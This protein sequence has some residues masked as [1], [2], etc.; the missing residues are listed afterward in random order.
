METVRA[1][2]AL[3]EQGDACRRQ[4]RI[5]PFPRIQ[6][7]SP[8][9]ELPRMEL[10]L[11]HGVRAGNLNCRDERLG[12]TSSTLLEKYFLR[13][14]KILFVA[15]SKYFQRISGENSLK[16]FL[17]CGFRIFHRL[18]AAKR[19]SPPDMSI[20][21]HF[22]LPE[23]C[24]LRPL[25]QADPPWH[26]ASPFSSSASSRSYRMLFSRSFRP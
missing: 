15:P 13:L 8:T 17:F 3:A 7:G 9:I 2:T 5:P 19:R 1:D 26:S 4:N 11:R 25:F 12:S 6:N 23:L 22:Q 16:K 10:Y 18:H 14:K 21:K 24:G 20:F